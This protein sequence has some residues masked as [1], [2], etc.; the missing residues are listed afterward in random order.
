MAKH[1]PQAAKTEA[2]APPTFLHDDPATLDADQ[3]EAAVRYHNWRYF[4][5]DDAVIPDQ[6]YDQLAQRLRALRP[7][8]A[9]LDALSGQI[10]ATG[11]GERVAHREPMRSL[12]KCYDHGE[13]VKWAADIEGE[14]VASPKLDGA[15]VSIRYDGSGRFELAATRGDGRRGEPIGH[16]VARIPGVPAQLPA[17]RG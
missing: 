11:E 4:E 2:M 10:G 3:L 17:A 9:V 15:A 5:R 13:L 7:D 1:D 12:A 16:N 6:I 14:L 8:S